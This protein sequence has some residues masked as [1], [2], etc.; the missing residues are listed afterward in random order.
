[1]GILGKI[2]CAVGVCLILSGTG[3]AE[4]SSTAWLSFE[5]VRFG[6]VN[7]FIPVIAVALGVK[8]GPHSRYSCT[9]QEKLTPINFTDLAVF[10]E[11]RSVVLCSD[12]RLFDHILE[13]SRLYKIEAGPDDTKVWG[14]F[15]FHVDYSRDDHPTEIF[16]VTNSGFQVVLDEIERDYKIRRKQVPADIAFMRK[17]Y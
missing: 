9:N 2:A 5:F 1:M 8:T 7:G 11:V 6:P 14:R 16:Y 13:I 4:E 12:Q 17:Y 3:M 10:T 15:L